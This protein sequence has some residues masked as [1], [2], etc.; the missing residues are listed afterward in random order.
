MAPH[1]LLES[2]SEDNKGWRDDNVAVLERELVQALKIQALE[3]QAAAAHELPSL[4][5]VLS[6]P[7]PHRSS[8]PSHPQTDQQYDQG[9]ASCGSSEE[10]GHGSLILDQDQEEEEQQHHERAAEE[11]V[12]EKADDNWEGGQKQ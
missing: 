5:S 6:F 7:C 10:P 2:L 8:E 12:T 1:F 3:L 9:G 4:A 11:A